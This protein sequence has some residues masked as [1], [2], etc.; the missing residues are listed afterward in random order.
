MLEQ[1]SHVYA[2]RDSAPKP[3]VY[4][5]YCNDGL[6]LLLE[7]LKFNNLISPDTAPRMKLLTHLNRCIKGFYVEKQ[8]KVI[9]YQALN[10]GN[11]RI[12]AR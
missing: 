11:I 2:Q 9:D 4:A 10:C 6:P 7:S 8:K 5:L 1:G 3:L 12:L